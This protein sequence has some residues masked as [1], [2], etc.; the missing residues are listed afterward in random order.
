MEATRLLAGE[1]ARLSSRP[2]DVHWRTGVWPARN[3][4]ELE[5]SSGGLRDG[6]G[7]T[8]S[9]W[10]SSIVITT[11]SSVSR[12]ERESVRS[13][14][15]P[16]PSKVER[17]IGCLRKTARAA[18][19]AMNR[20][21]VDATASSRTLPYGPARLKRVN[22]GFLRRVLGTSFLCLW[23]AW[24]WK[25]D[26]GRQSVSENRT[27]ACGTCTGCTRMRLRGEQAAR[28]MS[29]VTGSVSMCAIW[30]RYSTALCVVSCYSR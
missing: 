14:L 12:S 23:S 8:Q 11:E 9:T 6:C 2:V 13:L 15:L 30:N 4:L 29:V 26:T 16:L 18:L 20:S 21:W 17:T 10:R 19:Q 7:R 25:S 22:T 1:G 24:E 27:P 3:Q 5:P 28:C